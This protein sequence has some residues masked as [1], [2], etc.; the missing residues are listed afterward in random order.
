MTYEFL[1][2]DYSDY[3]SHNTDKS[4]RPKMSIHSLEEMMQIIDYAKKNGREI[5]V[6]KLDTCLLDWS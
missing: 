5:A 3:P 4:L 6:Y 1:I 2:L